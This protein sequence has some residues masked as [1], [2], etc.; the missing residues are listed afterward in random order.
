MCVTAFL[1]YAVFF[2]FSHQ[3]WD[4]N[5]FYL[6]WKDPIC[7]ARRVAKTRKLIPFLLSVIAAKKHVFDFIARQL[8]IDNISFAQLA[9]T[10]E[11]SLNGVRA[12]STIPIH[13]N[14][15]D[16]FLQHYCTTSWWTHRL[17][18]I[19]CHSRDYCS[20]SNTL[21]QSKMSMLITFLRTSP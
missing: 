20:V 19:K 13:I 11:Y 7:W 15:T 8:N 17:C 6:A 2:S 4:D 12:L 5:L 9:L 3:A 10:I 18:W 21:K 1:L 16:I 14:T